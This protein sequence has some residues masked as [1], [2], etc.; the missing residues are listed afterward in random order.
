MGN[1]PVEELRKPNIG[2]LKELAIY[3]EGIKKGQGNLQPLGFVHLE[4]LWATIHYL[5]KISK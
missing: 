2:E 1:E 4:N 3:L 5:H